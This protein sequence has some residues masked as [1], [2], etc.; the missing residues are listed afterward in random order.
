MTDLSEPAPSVNLPRPKPCKRR[1]RRISLARWAGIS[2]AINRERFFLEVLEP[3]SPRIK[4]SLPVVRWMS[5][6]PGMAATSERGE[7]A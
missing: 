2:A 1:R 5:R 4:V 7:A 3:T 6:E